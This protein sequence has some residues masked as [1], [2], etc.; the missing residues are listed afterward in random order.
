MRIRTAPKKNKARRL[1]KPT[2]PVVAMVSSG[3]YSS[4]VL[5]AISFSVTALTASS[6][7]SPSTVSR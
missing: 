7:A 4:R 5:A 6:V 2:R 1:V 3:A